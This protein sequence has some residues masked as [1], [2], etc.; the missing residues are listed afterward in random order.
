M[1]ALRRLCALLLLLLPLVLGAGNRTGPV[2]LVIWHGMGEC[3]GAGRGPRRP[4]PHLPRLGRPAAGPWVPG[5]PPPRVQP[6]APGREG[7]RSFRAE[8]AG[9]LRAKRGAP[10]PAWRL[11]H[12]PQSSPILA[13]LLGR[14]GRGVGAPPSGE[15]GGE[16]SQR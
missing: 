5:S 4:P 13:S 11:Q 16:G 15:T 3:Q 14:L 6:V 8:G 1:A 10:L 9:V 7:E 2:P 12:E